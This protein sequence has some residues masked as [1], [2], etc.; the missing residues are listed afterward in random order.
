MERLAAD[1]FILI[2][3]EQGVVG[4]TGLR[5]KFKIRAGSLFFNNVF[6]SVLSRN[7]NYTEPHCPFVDNILSL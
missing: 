5:Q 7:E 4:L 3:P 1:F 2:Y 6:Y